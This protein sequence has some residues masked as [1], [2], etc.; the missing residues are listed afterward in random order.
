MVLESTLGGWKSWST[1]KL[2]KSA[3]ALVCKDR[4]RNNRKATC[5]NPDMSRR[6]YGASKWSS[7]G[8]SHSGGLKTRLGPSPIRDSRKTRMWEQTVITESSVFG[9][10]FSDPHRTE[11]G[12]ENTSGLP[13]DCLRESKLDPTLLSSPDLSDPP[14]QL[15]ICPI[16]HP[17]PSSVRRECPSKPNF[18]GWLVMT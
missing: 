9:T 8:V 4:D 17:F 7:A 15:S 18:V 13:T 14:H 16:A 12:K 1:F 10:A 11:K 6:S 3:S 2:V 5:T